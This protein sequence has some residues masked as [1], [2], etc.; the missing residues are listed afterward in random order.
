MTCSGFGRLKPHE[1]CMLFGRNPYNGTSCSHAGDTS[2]NTE[3]S[4]V[5]TRPKCDSQRHLEDIKLEEKSR[6]A[7]T[8]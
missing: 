5:I 8:G 4:G 3:T 2:R 1:T 6:S 7:M